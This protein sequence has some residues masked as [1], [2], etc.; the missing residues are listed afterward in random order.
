MFF[1]VGGDFASGVGGGGDPRVPPSVSSKEC[2]DFLPVISIFS[3]TN[4]GS[5]LH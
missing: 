1:S 3:F 4:L 5:T 2:T